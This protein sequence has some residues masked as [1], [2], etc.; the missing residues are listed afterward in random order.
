MILTSDGIIAPFW[1]GRGKS[2]ATTNK[3]ECARIKKICPRMTRINANYLLLPEHSAVPLDHSQPS[4][5][6]LCHSSFGFRHLH[7]L[8]SIRVHLW[9]KG[10]GVSNLMK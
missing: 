4:S 5:S 8:V 2:K 7:G 9:L 10:A 3:H 6:F 1:F